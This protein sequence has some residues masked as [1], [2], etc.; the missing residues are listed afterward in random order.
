[1]SLLLGCWFAADLLDPAKFRNSHDGL[2][3]VAGNLFGW[4]ALNRP[5]QAKE[6]PE[7]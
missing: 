5:G 3:L 1:V 6:A 4:L 2:L 7:A